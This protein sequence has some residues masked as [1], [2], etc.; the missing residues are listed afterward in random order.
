M[1][2]RQPAKTGSRCA[3]QRCG[4]KASAGFLQQ[5]WVF[6]V[7]AAA[8][9]D[10]WEGR[11]GRWISD[12]QGATDPPTVSFFFFLKRSSSRECSVVAPL[13]MLNLSTAVQ[14]HR[15]EKHLT[16]LVISVPPVK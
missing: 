9:A 12:M 5:R 1:I 16:G 11:D 10:L 8:S 4:Y 15:T 7:R 13:K 3:L 2:Q 14:T 6:L